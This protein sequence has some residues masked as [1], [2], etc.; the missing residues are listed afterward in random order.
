M[1]SIILLAT[2]AAPAPEQ[3]PLKKELFSNE[4]WYKNQ[5]GKEQ[6]FKGLLER[7]PG[8]GPRIG[9]F[10]PYRLIM[11]QVVLVPVTVEKDGKIVTEIVP[12]IRKVVREVYVGG[13]PDLLAPFVGKHIKLIG[14]A[15]D[16]EVVG[17]KHEEIW[18]AR[19]EVIQAD[20]KREKKD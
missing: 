10:N 19:L 4:S 7:Q 20:D 13:Q 9:R 11:T 12:E 18:P 14:K 15:V 1:F 16:L 3:S 2:L 6:E 8:G 5:Q 17:R